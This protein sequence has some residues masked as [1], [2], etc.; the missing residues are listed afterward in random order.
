M[1]DNELSSASNAALLEMIL[2]RLT[3]LDSHMSDLSEKLHDVLSQLAYSR[4]DLTGAEDEVHRALA[5]EIGT[6]VGQKLLSLSYMSAQQQNG[7][8]LTKKRI[9]QIMS[10]LCS[11]Y[12]A[13]SGPELNRAR[14]LLRARKGDE[15]WQAAGQAALQIKKILESA[16]IHG[17]EFVWDYEFS[18]G[19]PIDETRQ[20]AWSTCDP[21]SDVSFVV[22]PGYIADGERYRLQE[23]FTDSAAS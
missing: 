1:R 22:V 23:V 3:D 18:T 21:T 14:R 5:E 13:P 8:Q 19:L 16:R 2:H 12:L 4:E 15:V 10:K 7:S 11:A 17:I 6:F 9:A 20:Q